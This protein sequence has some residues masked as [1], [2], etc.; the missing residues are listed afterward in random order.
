MHYEKYSVL[1]ILEKLNVNIFKVSTVGLYAIPC[2]QATPCWKRLSFYAASQKILVSTSIRRT[3]GRRT[4]SIK[5][6]SVLRRTLVLLSTTGG[7]PFTM[8]RVYCDADLFVMPGLQEAIFLNSVSNTATYVYS[9][10]TLQLD[11]QTEVDTVQLP[12]AISFDVFPD[13]TTIS[14]VLMR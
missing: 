1:G 3:S 5:G 4:W 6:A 14:D 2:Q 8:H 12:Q 9:K 10:M 7:L 13:P 11:Q